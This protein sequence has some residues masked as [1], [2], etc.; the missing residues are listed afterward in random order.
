MDAIGKYKTTRHNRNTDYLKLMNYPIIFNTWVHLDH[1]VK[2]F[3][4]SSKAS[5][6]QGLSSFD[7]VILHCLRQCIGTN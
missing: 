5:F 7:Q 4:S 2:R 3:A 6:Y 1:L